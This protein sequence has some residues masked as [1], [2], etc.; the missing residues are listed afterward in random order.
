MAHL[1]HLSLPPSLPP[2]LPSP[3]PVARPDAEMGVC[4]RVIQS[5][6]L[7]RPMEQE[8]EGDARSEAGNRQP[9]GDV[10]GDDLPPALIEVRLCPVPQ[11]SYKSQDKMSASPFSMG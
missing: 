5:R 8:E 11:N 10:I 3:P 4:C 2:L 1:K 6:H 9:R 7:S